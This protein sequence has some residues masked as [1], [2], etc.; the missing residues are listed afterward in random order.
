[1]KKQRGFS[2]VELMV[3]IVILGV[4]VMLATTISM[5]TRYRWD[6]RGVARG[7]TA[8]YYQLKQRASRENLPCRISFSQNKY[9]TWGCLEVAGVRSWEKIEDIQFGIAKKLYIFE[10]GGYPDIAI[11]SRGMVYSTNDNT[12]VSLT[13]GNIQ[14]IELRCPE[15]IDGD[16]GDKFTISLYPY[17]GINVKAILSKPF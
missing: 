14:N 11:D 4:I 2:L 8:T 1:M 10:G 9:T 15:V 16:S 17:G 3:G 5:K 12:P 6:L 7:I 13:L